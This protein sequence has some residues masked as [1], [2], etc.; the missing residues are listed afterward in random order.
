ME[1]KKIEDFV[2]LLT[3]KQIKIVCA[4]SITGGLLASTII[5]IPGASSVLLGSIVSYNPEFKNKVLGVSNQTLHDKTAE[6]FE[7]T[8]EMVNGIFNLFPTADLY[9]AVTGVASASVNGYYVD[10]AIGQIY[11]VIMYKNSFFEFSE[12]ILKN[13]RNLIRDGAVEAIFNYI[14]EVVVGKK[15]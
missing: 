2:A 11:V 10:K 7:V 13:E 6:S 15:I 12:I 3:S 5:S 8:R 1:T 4:E 14:I 9:V